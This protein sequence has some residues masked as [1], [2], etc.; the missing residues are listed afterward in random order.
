[1]VKFEKVLDG[2]S[3]Y[4]NKNVYPNIG[5]DW[6]ELMMRLAVGR[7]LNN[8]ENVKQMVL[9]NGFVRTF[10]II[11]SEGNVDIE[12]LAKDL[13]REISNKGKITVEIPMLG[14]MSF[15]PADID[16]IYQEITGGIL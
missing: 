2:L 16:E 13:K 15:V 11:D 12:N 5:N 6:Q 9:S 14:K 8:P 4:I 1:M 10:G 3:R 7:I